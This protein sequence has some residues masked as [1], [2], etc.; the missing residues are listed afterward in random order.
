M[1]LW[2]DDQAKGED[3]H[4]CINQRV[5][6]TTALGWCIF[7]GAVSCAAALLCLRESVEA[8]SRS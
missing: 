2:W 8:V 5:I 7:E 3:I 1:E 6:I 4:C